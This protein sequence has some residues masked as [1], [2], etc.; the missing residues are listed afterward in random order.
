MSTYGK[1]V[2]IKMMVMTDFKVVLMFRESPILHIPEPVHW[3]RIRH[4]IQLW[5]MRH[6]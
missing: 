2:M 4:V 3:I 1:C 5:L 6:E